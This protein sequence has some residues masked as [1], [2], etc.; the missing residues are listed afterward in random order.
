MGGYSRR[1]IFNS[2]ISALLAC[3]YETVSS[4][5]LDHLDGLRTVSRCSAPGRPAFYIA[6]I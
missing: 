4:A 6:A 3:P 1:F 2:G 5:F